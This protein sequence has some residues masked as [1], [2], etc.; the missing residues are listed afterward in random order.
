MKTIIISIFS[1]LISS[2]GFFAQ[3]KELTSGEIVFH[4]I[5]KSDLQATS[6]MFKSKLDLSK[7]TFEVSIPV[8]NFKFKSEAGQSN[9]VSEM[10]S[11]SFPELI[12]KGEISS[13]ADITIE[14]RHIVILKGEAVIK[15]KTYQFKSNGLLVNKRGETILT[16]SFLVNA[17]MLG[18]KNENSEKMEVSFTVN[19]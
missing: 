14:Q 7:K 15:G 5:L 11:T 2:L 13:N 4:T 17:K 3:G 10:N 16:S 8:E 18:L 6:T 9:F 12:I 1:L 19:Y